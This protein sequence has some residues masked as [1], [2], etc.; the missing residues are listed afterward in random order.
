MIGDA[1]IFP[2]N[3]QSFSISLWFNSDD[4]GKGNDYARQLF[5]FGGPSFNLGF[6]NPALPSSNSLEVNRRI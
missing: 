5:G 1:S 3:N 2:T 6:D 4:V